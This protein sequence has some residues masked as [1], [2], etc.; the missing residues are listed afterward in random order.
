MA[1]NDQI[2]LD[3]IV[4]EQRTSRFPSANKSEFFEMYVVEQVLK[5]FD[6]SDE[7]IESGLVG[8]GGDGG[9][10]AI[11]TFANGELVREDFDYEPLKKNVLIEVVIIQSNKVRVIW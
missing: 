5:D 6:L 11:Y 3:Q 8:N 10:D 4:E 1:N 2:I 7:E 9:I